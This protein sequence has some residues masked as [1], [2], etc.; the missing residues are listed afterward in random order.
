MADQG[1]INTTD[2]EDPIQT[3]KKYL[4]LEIMSSS[5]NRKEAI[6]KNILLVTKVKVT[7]VCASFDS[8]SHHQLQDL[9][10]HGTKVKVTWVCASFDSNSH[11]QLQDLLPHGTKV[12]VTWVCA[13]FDSNSR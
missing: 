8:N 9:L 3:T 7:W 12:K 4:I 5:Q 1:I 6:F 2:S 13:S 11:H 10:P